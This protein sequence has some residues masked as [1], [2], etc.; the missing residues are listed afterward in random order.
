[1]TTVLEPRMTPTAV[2]ILRTASELFY[3]HGIRAVGVERIAEEA[4]TTKKTIYDRFGSKDGLIN[5][6]LCERR[7]RWRAYVTTYVDE[8]HPEPGPARVL[9]VLDALE[10]WLARSSRGCGFVNAYAELAGTGH[11]ALPVIAEEKGWTRDYYVRLLTE[12]DVP[13]AGRRGRELA[14]VQEGATVQLTAGSQPEA[15]ADAR[16]LATR[17]VAAGLTARDSTAGTV[18]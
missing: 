7:D 4:G 14:L 10:G 17:L 6:Y 2:R 18:G 8:H 1:M 12:L 3:D 5:A 16:S 9:A 15:L 13:E 11:P